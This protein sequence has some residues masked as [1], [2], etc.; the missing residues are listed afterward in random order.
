MN[1]ARRAPGPSGSDSVTGRLRRVRG[2]A[3]GRGL[4]ESGQ[5]E[6]ARRRGARRRAQTE[7]DPALGGLGEHLQDH[8]DPGAREIAR[9][10]QIQDGGGA[11]REDAQPGCSA[12]RG[13]R[14]RT[15]GPARRRSPTARLR[16]PRARAPARPRHRPTPRRH[17][18]APP[19][20]PRARRRR[21]GRT[22]AGRRPASPSR[23]RRRK[24]TVVPAPFP[25]AWVTSTSSARAVISSSPRPRWP[26]SSGGGRQVPASWTCTRTLPSGS[27][28]T[29]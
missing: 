4:G 1:L 12:P 3:P 6:H 9:R 17:P 23:D 2:P 15:P 28:F 8:A 5:R 27:R 18:A 16:R 24:P 7:A 10:P 29:R 25:G 11:R 22:A 21:R 13:P 19:R 14:P 20:R 26:L